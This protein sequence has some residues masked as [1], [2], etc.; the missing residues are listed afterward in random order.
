MGFTTG[1]W[2]L[3]VLQVGCVAGSTIMVNTGAGSSLGAGSWG[4]QGLPWVTGQDLAARACPT[5]QPGAWRPGPPGQPQA[6]G[7]SLG[8]RP[9]TWACGWMQGAGH[10]AGQGRAGQHGAGSSPAGASLQQ[11]LTAPGCC[12]GALSS[13]GYPRGGQGWWC[14]RGLCTYG[15]LVS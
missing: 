4:A 2:L 6:W 13:W 9:A 1:I 12:C 10:M 7:T 8:L 3:V 14:P 11:G 15:G 5:A